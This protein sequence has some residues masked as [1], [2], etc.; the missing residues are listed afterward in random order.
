MSISQLLLISP[1]KE[2]PGC[3][4]EPAQNVLS[5]V[6]IGLFLEDTG[7]V[8]TEHGLGRV[9]VLLP[10]ISVLRQTALHFVSLLPC[11]VKRSHSGRLE[12]IFSGLQT[13]TVVSAVSLRS[14]LQ[15]VF[16]FSQD[17]SLL[18]LGSSIQDSCV[19]M[20]LAVDQTL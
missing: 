15:H 11:M 13:G 10:S 18:S 1:F 2:T 12:V 7:C 9:G 19:L 3:V 17:S 20:C 14:V 5:F 16:E 4:P 6:L 8:K